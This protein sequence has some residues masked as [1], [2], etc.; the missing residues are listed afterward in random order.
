MMNS[1]L[2]RHTEVVLVDG[3][4]I[5]VRTRVIRAGAFVGYTT[6]TGRFIGRA[7]VAAER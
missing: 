1:M 4:T 6:W 3:R 7:N 5:A 2:P